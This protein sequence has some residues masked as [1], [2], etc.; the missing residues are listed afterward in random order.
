[1]KSVKWIATIIVTF[2][3]G[4]FAHLLTTEKIPAT[5]SID[6]TEF[7][8][9]D[10]DKPA[11]QNNKLSFPEEKI[12]N[13]AKDSSTVLDKNSTS[14]QNIAD[15]EE[16]TSLKPE[17]QRET[18]LSHDKVLP[19]PFDDML[20][21]IDGSLRDKYKDYA[22]SEPKDDWDTR[23]Q[24]KITDFILSRPAATDIKIDSVNCNS[25]ICEIRLEEEKRFLLMATFAELLQESWLINEATGQFNFNDKYGYMLLTRK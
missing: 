14:S 16:S 1:M 4:Y 3:A 18:N 2:F 12:S 15:K 23:M 17:S 25:N 9:N 10:A 20:D 24:S 19:K 22:A 11:H 7:R 8:Y 13:L 21:K 6:Q 5:T